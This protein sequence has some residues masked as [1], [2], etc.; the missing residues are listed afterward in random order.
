MDTYTEFREETLKRWESGDR[1]GMF[2]A[3]ELLLK[4]GRISDS[5]GEFKLEGKY[6]GNTPDFLTRGRAVFTNLGFFEAYP[7]FKFESFDDGVSFYELKG[8]LTPEALRVYDNLSQSFPKEI[9]AAFQ[10]SK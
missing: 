2:N 10:E 4:V 7:D 8:K 6:H 3:L 1:E 5:Q 9:K